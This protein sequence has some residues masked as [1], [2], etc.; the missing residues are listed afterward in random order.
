MTHQEIADRVFEDTGVKVTRSSVSGALSRAGLTNPT[1]YTSWL[2][3]K[4]IKSEHNN[5]HIANMLRVGARLEAGEKVPDRDAAKFESWQRRLIEADAVV[6]Y[7]YESNDGW[8]Y[9]RRKPED[10]GLIRAPR[11]SS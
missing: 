6:T 8:Y 11:P 5:N 4:P 3:W 1:R 7:V 2:P 10:V 9:V